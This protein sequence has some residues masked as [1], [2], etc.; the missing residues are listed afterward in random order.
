MTI[1]DFHTHVFPDE[2]AVAAMPG[3]EAEAGVDAAFDGTLSG[4]I[5][6]MDSAGVAVSVTQPVATKP[7]QVR[8]INDWAASTASSRIIPF[9]TMHPGLDDAVSEIA[10][11]AS[12]GIRGFK[13]HPEYQ[14]FSPDEPRISY[15]L[16]AAARHGLAVLFHAGRD[17]AINTYKGTPSAFSRMLDGHPGATVVLA[18]MGGFRDWEQVDEHLIG[19]EVWLD[20]SFSLGHMPNE[21]FVRRVRQ[22]D[23]RRVLFGSD[24][25][26]ADVLAEVRALRACGLD[27]DELAA[28]LGDNALGLLGR[29]D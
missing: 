11:M 29:S 7:S 17:I 23:P 28:V 14:A 20:T 18:H 8:S 12:L 21:E 4:L 26:W 6:V 2:V 5:G 25:P 9:G 13:M 10:R 16:D 24:G 22:H 1:I 19:R 27:A 15:I 3:L